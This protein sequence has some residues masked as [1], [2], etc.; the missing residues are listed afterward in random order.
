MC[1]ITTIAALIYVNFP[2]VKNVFAL[3]TRYVNNY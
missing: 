1:E 2:L 3:Y